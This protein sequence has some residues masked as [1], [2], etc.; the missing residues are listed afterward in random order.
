MRVIEVFRFAIRGLRA[1]KLRSGLTTLGILIGV[2]AVILLIAVGQGSGAAVQARISNLGSN[3]LTVTRQAGGFGRAAASRTGT[4]SQ[5]TNLTVADAQLLATSDQ[6]PDV[7]VVAPVASTSGTATYAGATTTIN[8]VVGT[9]PAYL[10]ISNDQ[11]ATGSSFSAD[12]V[13]NDRKVV[14]IGQTVVTNLFGTIDPIGKTLQLGGVPYTVIGTL[15]AKG[16]GSTF[17]DPDNVALAPLTT[18]QNSL[19]GFGS[20]SEI[21]VQAT[22]AD[23]SNAAQAE[24]TNLLLQAHHDTATNADFTVTNEASLLSTAQSTTQTFTVLLAAVAAIS[25]LVGGIGVTNIML[26]TVTER[27]R[28]IG[29]RKALGA[30]RGAILGQ[31]LIEA[32]LLSVVGG[33]LGV[34]A[35]VV[36]SRFTI[37]GIKP[38]LVPSSILLAFGVS[39]VIGLVF[40]SLPANRA[41]KL[42]PIEALRHE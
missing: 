10:P 15:V 24:V 31:F 27:T 7:G 36:G 30:P 28:E 6:D 33:A 14:V 13:N 20:L 39:A 9:Y 3:L 21:A 1:N 12:D 26:V 23:Q 41:A 25:L 8:Q 11:I 17:N 29:I 22:G 19:T 4:Q 32:V 5:T 38:V 42:H 16:G 35:G 2:G 37:D 18:V 40:G 34:V